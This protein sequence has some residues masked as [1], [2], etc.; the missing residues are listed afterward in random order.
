MN[1]SKQLSS[2]NFYSNLNAFEE[3]SQVAELDQYV[4][5][6]D[7]WVILTSDVVGST[8]AIEAGNYKQVNMAGAASIMCIL[9]A[10]DSIEVPFS[11]GGDGGLVVVPAGVAK[12]AS[13]ELQ[14]LQAGCESIF[15]L[16]LRAAAIP[17]GELR[18]RN[19]DIL[20][21]KF[22]LN[23]DNHLAMFA[24]N[25]TSMADEWLKSNNPAHE[26][27]RLRSTDKT[28]PDLDGLSCRWEPLASMNGVMLTIIIKPADDKKF[29]YCFPGIQ[30]IEQFTCR[31]YPRSIPNP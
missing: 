13:L 10:C 4:P 5:L 7:D 12:Q 14:K 6:P 28:P 9:N 30:G 16:S 26:K 23:D 8:L 19:G 29:G 22:A 15:G 1:E 2:K 24:G 27:F 20:V 17:L 25:G 18:A 11:F 21:R 31:V 3:F